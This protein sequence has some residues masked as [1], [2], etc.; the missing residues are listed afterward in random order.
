MLDSHQF[1]YHPH[2]SPTVGN[3]LG[4]GFLEKVYENA[5]AYELHKA[6]LRVEQQHGIEVRY[7]GILVGKFFA[8]LLVE[9]CV[10]VELKAAKALDVAHFAQCLNYLKATGLTVCLL[11]NFGNPRAEFK[12]IVRNF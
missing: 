12:R 9:G 7:D 11:I 6:R 8:N 4:Y 10:L 1:L 2:F 5:L 3:G